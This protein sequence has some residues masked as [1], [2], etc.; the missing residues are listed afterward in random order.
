MIKRSVVVLALCVCLLFPLA[1]SAYGYSIGVGK[2]DP[3]TAKYSNSNLYPI[4]SS[5][6]SVAANAAA[7]WTNVSSCPYSMVHDEV[8]GDTFSSTIGAYNRGSDSGHLA[9]TYYQ[10]NNG[11]IYRGYTWVNTYYSWSTSGASSSYDLQSCLTHEFGHWAPLGDVS[12]P[13]DA[14]MYKT[15]AKGETKKRSLAT[16]DINGIRAIY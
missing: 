3:P 12:S 5:W 1:E 11:A 7:T 4:S 14:T 10:S 13:T 15:M 9:V 8:Y 2:W 6:M 16:D